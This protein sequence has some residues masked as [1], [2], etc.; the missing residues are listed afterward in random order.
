MNAKEVAEA[1]LR[2]VE[3][4]GDPDIPLLTSGDASLNEVKSVSLQT[5]ASGTKY[6]W[7]SG[8]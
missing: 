6:V 4:E 2:I 8:E 1:I 5:L 7:L 3:A